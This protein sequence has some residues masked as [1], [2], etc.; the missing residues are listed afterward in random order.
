MQG[1][2]METMQIPVET[3]HNLV[4]HLSVHTTADGWAKTCLEEL[5]RE[6]RRVL[7]CDRSW[8]AV[9]TDYDRN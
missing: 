4:R 6:A 9:R 5:Q 8:R 1:Q 3:Y 2:T 7:V